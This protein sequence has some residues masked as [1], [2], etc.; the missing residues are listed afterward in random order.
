MTGPQESEV[1]KLARLQ[2]Q[3]E[4][5]PATT[6]WPALAP[7]AL[8]GVA[9]EYVRMIEPHTEADPAGILFQF[10]VFFGNLIGRS[11]HF[12]VEADRHYLNLF[13]VLV[14]ESAKGRKGVSSGQAKR[15]FKDVDPFWAE[16]CIQ[17][18]LSSGEGL[19]H[20]VRDPREPDPN[21]PNAIQETPVDKRLCSLEGEFASVLKVSQKHGNILSAVIRNAW[22]SGDL[23][24]L[25]KNSP[26]RA[27]GA[28]I[29]IVGHIT[30]DELLRRLDS[31]EAANGFGNR[32]LWCLVKRS[33]FLPEGGRSHELDFSGIQAKLHRCVELARKTGEIRRDA[34]A[35][36]V[37]AQVYPH[38]SGGKPGLFGTMIGRS[39]AQ[40]MRLACLMA[41]L[42]ESPVVKKE[43][44][45]S[46]LALWDYCEQSARWIFG[47]AL[48]DPVADEVLQ[49]LKR[50]PDGLSRAEITAL[51]NRHLKSDEVGNALGR[52]H[53]KDLAACKKVPTAG[54]PVERWFSTSESAH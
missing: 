53:Q 7:Q 36:E 39:E 23:R 22:D 51:F 12:A 46:A 52:L 24:T 41:L 35:G 8:H 54:R 34:E 29:S 15:L 28:H 10:L 48:G 32:F 5:E 14:G 38:L 26:T 20:A 40:A 9:G 31:T 25:T 18:G 43:H 44:L 1:E 19:I 42:D 11:A 27:T 30:K 33:K 6:P 4:T 17:H 2:E 16:N 3:S 45:L 37:W 49:A 13:L 21:E 47:D 50:S